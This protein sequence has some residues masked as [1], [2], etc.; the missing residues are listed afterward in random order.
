MLSVFKKAFLE[1]QEQYWKYK[2]YKIKNIKSLLPPSANLNK[3][4]R[5]SEKIEKIVW[6]LRAT[7]LLLG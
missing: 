7:E 5:A 1:K 6:S 3:Q 2:K 4:Y